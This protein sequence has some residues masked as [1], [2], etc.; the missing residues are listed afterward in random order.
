ML[1]L[2]PW[3]ASQPAGRTNTTQYLDPY[4]T[5]TAPTVKASPSFFCSSDSLG[6]VYMFVSSSIA[7]EK[8]RLSMQAGIEKFAK[9][10]RTNT[11]SIQQLKL[12]QQHVGFH[13]EQLKC[14][15]EDE[16]NRLGFAPQAK[17]KVTKRNMILA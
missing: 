16:A 4:I 7:K 11:I 5:H 12:L 10:I 6:A 13:P 8:Q 14:V 15:R 2:L 9:R 17:V 3:T 1:K